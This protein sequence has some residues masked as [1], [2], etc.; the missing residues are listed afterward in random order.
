MRWLRRMSQTNHS[1]A[2]RLVLAMKFLCVP[3]SE[4]ACKQG[5]ASIVRVRSTRRGGHEN[6]LILT[7][8]NRGGALSNHPVR[9]W[10]LGVSTAQSESY[11]TGGK[12]NSFGL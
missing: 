11:D 7:V 5:Y 9:N 4:K 10:I 2:P 6:R 12:S 8:W 1:Q 3:E